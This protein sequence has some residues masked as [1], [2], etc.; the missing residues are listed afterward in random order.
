MK[1]VLSPIGRYIALGSATFQQRLAYRNVFFLSLLA[2][3]MVLFSLFYLWRA[4]YA[5]RSE[6]GGFAWGEMQ[7]YLLLTFVANAVISLHS[8]VMMTWRILDGSIAMDLLKPLDY[9]TARF[10]EVIT[11]AVL[12]GAAAVALACV[13]GV[14]AGI[15]LLPAD[16]AHG[17][18][19]FV[20]FSLGVVIKF[21]IAYLAGL[22]CFWTNNGWGISWAHTAVSQLFSGALVPL[23]FLP[24]WLRTTA[25]WLP[26]KG[27]TYSPIQIF[28]GRVGV[29]ES[30]GILAQQAAW[31]VALW[32]LGALG[33]NV[34]V[35][36]VTIHGG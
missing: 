5:G 15:H 13:V 2:Q 22:A 27:M 18:L 29:A 34:M 1:R 28:L 36:K 32:I 10:V 25:E 12:E 17:L 7:T 16:A 30:C 3:L 11:T 23:P 24:L 31:A 20:S 21:G 35:R 26:F 19:A 9:Q 33:W 4:I 14:L 8:E 6:L